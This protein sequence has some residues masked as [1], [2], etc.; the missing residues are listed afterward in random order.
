MTAA[1]IA[2][3]LNLSQLHHSGPYVLMGWEG[4]SSGSLMGEGPKR[5]K[6]RVSSGSLTPRDRIRVARTSEGGMYLKM[7][8]KW[9]HGYM[10]T[11]CP[12]LL[13][14][15]TVFQSPCLRAGLVG[16]LLSIQIVT[17]KRWSLSVL[18]GIGRILPISQKKV[19]VRCYSCAPA[20]K[21][22]RILFKRRGQ[23][24][25]HMIKCVLW[26]FVCYMTVA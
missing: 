6:W 5:K 7:T 12:T 10:V 11:F 20:W 15:P 23:R 21:G 9:F 4:W 3:Q 14:A 8:C 2:G 13:L 1:R 16:S 22:K 25:H 24:Y 19:C 17:L 26:I 18:M